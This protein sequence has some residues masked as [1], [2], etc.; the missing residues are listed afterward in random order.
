MTN[1]ILIYKTKAGKFYFESEV[2]YK[3]SNKKDVL[4][5]IETDYPEPFKKTEINQ[6]I[7]DIADVDK[8]LQEIF[9]E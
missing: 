1:K 9:S 2:T 6:E 5:E 7:K 8:L 4:F 3:H